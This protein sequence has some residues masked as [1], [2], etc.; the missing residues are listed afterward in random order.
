[1][2]SCVNN[3]YSS[4]SKQDMDQLFFNA[5][6]GNDRKSFDELIGFVN[7]DWNEHWEKSYLMVAAE[8]NYDYISRVLIQRGADLELKD[9]DGKTALIIACENG[10]TEVIENLLDYGVDVNYK[11]SRKSIFGSND[12]QTP[13]M[14]VCDEDIKFENRGRMI[15]FIL[16]AGAKVNLLSSDGETALDIAIRNKNSST[17]DELRRN[18]AK[19][20][21]ELDEK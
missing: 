4:I 17:I 3:P 20:A 16:H 12:G 9:E 6:L 5:V 2:T 13:L 11:S 7:M 21:K 8:N 18:D 1:M 15:S 10:S 14:L 19:T